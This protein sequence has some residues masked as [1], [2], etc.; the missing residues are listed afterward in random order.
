[1]NQRDRITMAMVGP[2]MDGPTD[3]QPEPIRPIH[4]RN[5]LRNRPDAATQAWIDEMMQQ[6]LGPGGQAPSY[7]EFE[8]PPARHPLDTSVE[9]NMRTDN[10]PL[11]PEVIPPNAPAWAREHQSTPEFR[12]NPVRYA[13]PY[14][15]ETRGI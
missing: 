6:A 4:P 7:A 13:D 3:G 5:L 15:E 1:M 11:P 9:L 12:E 2:P 10:V 8:N 14:D